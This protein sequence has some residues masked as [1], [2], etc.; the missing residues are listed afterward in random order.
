MSVPGSSIPLFDLRLEPEDLEAV[1]RVLAAGQ[2]A[3]GAAG[4]AFE[5]AFADQLACRHVVAV[6]SGTAALHLACLAAGIGPGDEVIVPAITFVATANAVLYCGGT[7]VI[8]DVTGD[9]DLGIDPADVEARIT[10]RTRA[11]CAMHYGGYPAAVE[12]LRALCD[13][14]GIALLEDAAHAPSAHAGGRKAGTFGLAGAFSFF[15]NKVLS[16][17]EGGALATDDDGVAGMARSARARGLVDR[18][19]E[20]RA[21]LLLSRLAR[22]EADIARRR[23]LTL[24]Y[25]R[26][27]AGLDGV[28]VPYEALD[29]ASSS[30]YV[31]PVLLEQPERRPVVRARMRD[32]HAVQ[33]SVLYPAVHEL[34]AFARRFGRRSLPRAERVARTQLTLP[35]HPHL[36]AADQD[37]VVDALGEALGS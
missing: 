18:L 17:G 33:T 22:M 29:V 25:R 20:P 26:R 31:M 7:P 4:A 2:L 10:R 15:S 23:A 9:R 30:C 27:L 6:G 1:A 34:S 3:L 19:D 14:R 13:A 36:T 12:A 11:V 35:L 16:A 5:R 24:A 32:R 21:A 37:R 28:L 8:A